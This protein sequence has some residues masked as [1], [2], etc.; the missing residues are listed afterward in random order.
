LDDR[1]C[2]LDGSG[3]K[4]HFSR[5]P[6]VENSHS[7]SISFYSS[8][9]AFHTNRECFSIPNGR[10]LLSSSLNVFFDPLLEIFLRIA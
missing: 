6:K 1:S 7:L 8:S 2:A 3:P 9:L 5:G 4:M 10:F